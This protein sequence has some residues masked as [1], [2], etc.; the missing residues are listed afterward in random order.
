MVA[1]QGS[2][3]GAGF[4]AHSTG[5]RSLAA[6]G[7]L[8]GVVRGR[9]FAARNRRR[10]RLGQWPRWMNGARKL[11]NWCEQGHRKPQRL[12]LRTQSA[13][14]LWAPVRRLGAGVV[15]SL[16]IRSLETANKLCSILRASRYSRGCVGERHGGGAKKC[17]Q[18]SRQDGLATP[19]LRPPSPKP[20]VFWGSGT[21]IRIHSVERVVSR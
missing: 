13:A 11:L 19:P 21:P 17:V 16:P 14:S 20:M 7:G 5:K 10:R 6:Y 12:P 15:Q 8:L 3:G 2:Q 4:L 1:T 9:R 18:H